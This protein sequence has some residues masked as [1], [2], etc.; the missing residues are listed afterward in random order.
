[1]FRIFDLGERS[2]ESRRQVTSI[3]NHARAAHL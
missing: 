2:L 1:M 3:R